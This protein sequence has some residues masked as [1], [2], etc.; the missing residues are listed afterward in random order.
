MS[1]R[2]PSKALT[3]ADYMVLANAQQGFFI[4]LAGVGA[5]LAGAAAGLA[6]AAAGLAGAAGLY[7]VG[8]GLPGIA[9]ALGVFFS[10]FMDM[11]SSSS[12]GDVSAPTALRRR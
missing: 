9:W 2:P 4:G 10:G 11:T 8:A 3:L 5:G 12:E 7:G 1:Q 6:G